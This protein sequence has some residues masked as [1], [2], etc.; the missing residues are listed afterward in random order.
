MNR[1]YPKITISEEGEK[2]LDNGQMWMYKN[3]VVKL[4]EEIENGALV[5]IVTTKDRYLGTG[6]LSRNSHITVRILSKDTA[7]TFDRA[8]FKE[9]IQFAYTYRK[10]LESKNIT[11]CRLIFGEADQLPG[12]TVDRY[13]DILVSQISSYGLEQ[14]KDMLYEVLLEVLR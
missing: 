12:L 8:F 7:D 11:N 2:W 1:N 4:D 9:R 13:N 5:D 10:T 3:N 6:F 14:R